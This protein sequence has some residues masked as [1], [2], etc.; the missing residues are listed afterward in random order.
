MSAFENHSPASDRKL[1]SWMRSWRIS[2]QRERNGRART[3]RWS[4]STA[5]EAVCGCEARSIVSTGNG[6]RREYVAS[7]PSPLLARVL[8]ALHESLIAVLVQEGGRATV[9][10]LAGCYSVALPLHTFLMGVK[11]CT[12]CCIMRR[13]RW[14]SGKTA[15]G[16]WRTK[17][18]AHNGELQRFLPFR[19]PHLSRIRRY[20]A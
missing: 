12:C 18:G 6:K 14:D 5:L 16:D 20:N 13:R 11:Q 8:H 3:W 15:R 1:P 9:K 19:N 10:R 4:D 7:L 17:T 2:L